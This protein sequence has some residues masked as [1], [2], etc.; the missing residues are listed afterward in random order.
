M[1][2]IIKTCYKCKCEI[3]RDNNPKPQGFFYGEAFAY[4][5]CEACKLAVKEFVEGVPDA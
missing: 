4:D 2:E 1:N 5:L 3:S